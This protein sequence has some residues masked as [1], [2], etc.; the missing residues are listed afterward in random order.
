MRVV[1]DDPAVETVSL[2]I[3][4]EPSFEMAKAILNAGKHLFIEK[5]IA[6]NAEKAEILAE[7]ALKTGRV[8]HID[9]LMLFHHYS[10]D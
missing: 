6:E 5:P 1:L 7:L 10:P 9:H 2:A 4:T 8:L 3:Q